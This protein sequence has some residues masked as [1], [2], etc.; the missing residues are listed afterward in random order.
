MAKDTDIITYIGLTQRAVFVL[1][2]EHFFN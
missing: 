1:K 2:F